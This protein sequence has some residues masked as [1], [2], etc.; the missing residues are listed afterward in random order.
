MRQFRS[1]LRFLFT[2]RH[3]GAAVS[4]L[5]PGESGWW[6]LGGITAFFGGSTYTYVCYDY[7]SACVCVFLCRVCIHTYRTNIMHAL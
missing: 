5:F 7:A 3:P 1:R 4:F 2:V 6:G